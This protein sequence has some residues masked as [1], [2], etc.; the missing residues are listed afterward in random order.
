M[1]LGVRYYD[2]RLAQ[3]LSNDARSFDSGDCNLLRYVKNNPLTFVDP[4][5]FEL[6]KTKCLW[7]VPDG[8][9][10]DDT[11]GIQIQEVSPFAVGD[12]GEFTWSIRWKKKTPAGK[13]G[14]FILQKVEVH[15]HV[16]DC[17]GRDI[18]LETLQRV[19]GK[20]GN[21]HR[22]RT[23]QF[24]EVWQVNPFK[25]VTTYI[26]R[27]AT[28]YDD[29]FASPSFGEGTKGTIKVFG[30][31]GEVVGKFTEWAPQAIFTK[32]NPKTLA[33]GLHSSEFSPRI[34]N[35]SHQRRHEIGV[36]WDCC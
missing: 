36:E 6:R 2:S 32:N 20:V 23:F 7:Q 22:G 13:R 18:T 11:I 3:F 19:I 12:C 35:V 10:T 33:Q 9:S 31:Y 28:D 16:E 8:G 4:S 27:D 24:W 30:E 25:D 21:A 17:C 14:V 34:S 15:E 5:G 1:L 29:I 26:E